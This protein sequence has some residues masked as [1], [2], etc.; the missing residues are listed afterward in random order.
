MRV[1]WVRKTS[2]WSGPCGR[3]EKFQVKIT[4]GGSYLMSVVSEE[5]TADDQGALRVRW[6]LLLKITLGGSYLM[7]VLWV[8]KDLQVI[9]ALWVPLLL[10]KIHSNEK[11][12]VNIDAWLHMSLPSLA[13]RLNCISPHPQLSAE[14]RPV[15]DQGAVGELKLS[16]EDFIRRKLSTECVEWGKTC[17]WSWRC[18]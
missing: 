7:K 17:R 10:A 18:G 9:R 11:F 12:I 6:N 14:W 5:R 16:G 1:L 15:D 13:I 3:G 2:R 8:R 4:W